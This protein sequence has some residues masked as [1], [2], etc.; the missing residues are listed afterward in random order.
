MHQVSQKKVSLL[1][2]KEQKEAY[3]F[4]SEQRG[5]GAGIREGRKK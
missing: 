5:I 2:G 4:I 3:Y 1:D